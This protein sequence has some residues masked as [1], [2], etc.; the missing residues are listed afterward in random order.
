MSDHGEDMES[1]ERNRLLLEAV[2]DQSPVA[3]LVVSMPDLVLRQMNRAAVEALGIEDEPSLV[4]LPLS[5]V[6]RRQTWRDL[7][8][9][10]TPIVPGSTPTERALRG[11]RTT[12]VEFSVL[13]KDGTRRWFLGGGTP[14]RRDDGTVLAGVLAFRDVTERRVAEQQL[15]RMANEQRTILDTVSAGICLLRSN[16]IQWVNPAFEAMFG[17]RADEV[18]GQDTSSFYASAEEY[19][20]VY[21]D[22][23][24][25]LPNTSASY[26]TEVRLK[27]RSGEILWCHIAGRA[28]DRSQMDDSSIWVL[29]DIDPRK[30]AEEALRAS[31]ERLDAAQAHAHI[32]SW[33][34]GAGGEALF[35]SKEMFRL[36][37]L[38]P[39][40]PLPPL[41]DFLDMLHPD[42][43]QGLIAADQ[44][45]RGTGRIRPLQYRTNPARGP[46]RV[47]D[48]T[49]QA[50][51]D[52]AG[53]L[54]S[55]TGTLQDVTER[56]RVERE[57]ARLQDQL[58][59]AAK[60]EAVGRL[61]GGVAHDFN[62]L[63]TV[64]QGNTELAKLDLTPT[65]PLIQYLDQVHT[66][67]SSAA[68]L[69][70][71]LLAFSR[72]QMIEPRVLNLNDLIKTLRKML[73]RLIGEDVALETNLAPDLGS[74]KV[75]AGQFDQVI[76]NLAV[77]AR[78]A[79]PEG[80]RLSIETANVTMDEAWCATHPGL[81][82]GPYI[83]VTVSD[84]GHG[85]T[86]QIRERI[87][88]PF[89]TSKPK[90]RGT[91]LGLAMV[92]AV[93]SQSGGAI[94][95][96]SEVGHGTAFKILLPRVEEPAERFARISAIAEL[97][98]GTES[99]LLVEDERSVR[100]LSRS[101]LQRQ[102]YRVVDFSSGGE[103]LIYAE[104]HREPIHLLFTDIVLPGINGRELAE[105]FCRL[106]PET[107]VLFASGYT[108]D[109]ILRTGVMADQFHFIGKPYSLQDISRKVREVLNEKKPA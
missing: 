35:W 12:N 75:D 62:N 5:E 58:Q 3:M 96:Y 77:N 95:V 76:V 22:G 79:M 17:V 30:R 2:L 63:L 23:Y 16:R 52:S 38:D 78:D 34:I 61:A 46:E 45:I 88:E 41:S 65:D 18:C 31:Q 20:R 27:R 57:Q 56:K 60:M 26:T 64:I 10:D 33:E 83:R 50:V 91:G 97:P 67:A 68:D 19:Q 8:A 93:V 72:R 73:A 71:Q 9:D 86:K 108:E 54:V 11:E 101:F 94:D 92:F 1:R 29:Q 90:G 51:R 37:G 89:F 55:I 82:P 98:R 70:R 81:V 80:G 15:R 84:T 105:R 49:M 109:A 69:T 104:E 87:F 66:A 13:R 21:Q 43:R 40:A 24:Q 100:D 32:G 103:A 14:I 47:F 39:S 106:H 59:Q 107:A 102:G 25:T 85:M 74:V 4:N 7:S 36:F 53:T 28:I 42:D 6:R 99:T 48:A 44:E